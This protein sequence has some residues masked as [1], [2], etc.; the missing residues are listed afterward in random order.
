MKEKILVSVIVPTYNQSEYLE[1][2]LLNIINQKTNFH[3]EIIISNDASTDNSDSVIQD[4]IKS[5]V[6]NENISIK[7]FNHEKNLGVIKNWMFC[8]EQ[9]EGKYIAI[10]EGDDYWIDENKLQK[11]TDFLEQNHNYGLVFTN[12]KRINNNDIYEN[13]IIIHPD[14]SKYKYL[15]PENIIPT[16][17]TL[18]RND[19]QVIEEYFHL[20]NTKNW[21]IADYPLWFL[22]NKRYKIYFLRDYTAVYRITSNTASR[23]NDVIKKYLNT[24]T[25]YEIRKHNIDKDYDSS[26]MDDDFTL[27]SM[28]FLLQNY[29]K[30]ADF[31]N[32]IIN[33]TKHHKF[34]NSKKRNF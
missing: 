5:K 28:C 7:Y 31:K 17:T 11:Q 33:N 15:L 12:S 32:E 26:D 8:I 24:R 21:T 27:A 30:L 22:I 18:F 25:I 14:D 20:L 16:L 19:Q 2:T 23:P 10:C 1:L 4:I 9:C 3:Y 29:N 34:R 13:V 6:N